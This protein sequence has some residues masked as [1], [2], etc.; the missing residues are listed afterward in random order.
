[1][2]AESGPVILVKSLHMMIAVFLSA[3][4]IYLI[5]SALSGE[6]TPWTW[7]AAALL[8]FEGVVYVLSGWRCPLTIYAEW[9]GA[10]QGSVTHLV[11]PRWLADRFIQ[12]CAVGLVFSVLILLARLMAVF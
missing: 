6:I 11:L 9:L 10:S 7:L 12:I 2:K 4:E 1:V 5:Y 8:V 3:L